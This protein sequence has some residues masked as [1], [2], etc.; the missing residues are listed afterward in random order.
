MRFSDEAPAEVELRLN[1]EAGSGNIESDSKKPRRAPTC[2]KCG[3]LRKGH[4]KDH[5]PAPESSTGPSGSTVPVDIDLEIEE[6]QS[7]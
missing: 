3:Q 6:M 7:E 1:T 2:K 4:P 5:C